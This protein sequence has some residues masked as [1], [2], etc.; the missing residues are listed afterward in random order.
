[1]QRWLVDLISSQTAQTLP[2]SSSS[3]QTWQERCCSC[4]PGPPREGARESMKYWGASTRS[5]HRYRHRHSHSPP[6]RRCRH[7]IP[8]IPLATTLSLTVTE[9]CV[10]STAIWSSQPAA[11]PERPILIWPTQLSIVHLS[12]PS[13]SKMG[14]GPAGDQRHT[15]GAVPR[16]SFNHRT[17][18]LRCTV[19]WTPTSLVVPV[20][21]T[22]L[23]T[24]TIKLTTLTLMEWASPV[25][26]IASMCGHL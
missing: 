15:K 23:A 7:S 25:G 2:I 20:G 19:G 4:R 22:P 6:A 26:C 13:G 12:S 5:W 11:M 9:W 10:A 18:T 14:R 1:M 21:S 24:L 17:P 3:K 8:T 16:Y